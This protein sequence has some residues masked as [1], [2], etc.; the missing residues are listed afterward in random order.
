MGQEVRRSV[1]IDGVAA[2]RRALLEADE[3][4]VRG[5]VRL[6]IPFTD[7]RRV[8]ALDGQ[9]EVTH[10]RGTAVFELGARAERWAERICN[11]RTLVDKLD[12][13]PGSRVALVGVDDETF[14]E[15]LA[16]RTENLERSSPGSG[17][18][19]VFVRVDAV[20]D[21]ACISSLEASIARDGAIWVISP[22]GRS[23]LREAEV[24]DA[25]RAAGL[26]DTKVARFSDTHT[27]HKFV[28]PK[29][30]R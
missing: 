2:E 19:I 4:L 10:S 15:L 21:L 12:V 7:I 3:L 8:E 14:L 1:T 13:K 25:G 11:P 28:I 30:R 5:D 18:D 27:A 24:L 26:V 22:R 23:D 9:L 16:E 20:A 29:G 6:R 17:F